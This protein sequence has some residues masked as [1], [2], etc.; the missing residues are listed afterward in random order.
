MM[1]KENTDYN[2][3]YGKAISEKLPVDGFEWVDD[4]SEIEENFIKNYDEE[5]N[6]GYFIKTDIKYPKELHNN[7]SDLPFSM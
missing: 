5:S 7:N 3:L 6:V 1:K 2:N 4:M